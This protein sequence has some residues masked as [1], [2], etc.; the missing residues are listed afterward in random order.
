MGECNVD[1]FAFIYFYSILLSIKW[2]GGDSMESPPGF[3]SK[4]SCMF[5]AK[6]LIRSL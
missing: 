5:I 1:Y 4:K 2:R 3:C 6:D